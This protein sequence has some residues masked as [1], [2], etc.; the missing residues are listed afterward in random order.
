M[1][2]L[3]ENGYFLYNIWSQSKTYLKPHSHRSVLRSK[4]FYFS[5][6]KYIL[7]EMK[8]ASLLR[9]MHQCERYFKDTILAITDTI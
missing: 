3:G 6:V 5:Y 9:K 7:H 8:Q 2:T 4:L 1:A